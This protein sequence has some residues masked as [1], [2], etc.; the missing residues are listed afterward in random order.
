MYLTNF[1]L[2][3][4]LSL[5]LILWFW[6]GVTDLY[7]LTNSYIY[8]F[9]NLINNNAIGLPFSYFIPWKKKAIPTR[10]L[11]LLVHLFFQY[12]NLSCR[13]E[14][15]PRKFWL[16]F[17]WASYWLQIHELFWKKINCLRE[18][19]ECSNFSLSPVFPVEKTMI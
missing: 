4:G 5:F 11:C 9:L 8:L 13:P 17:L 14:T 10:I 18:I 7:H 2:L 1:K 16:F 19:C 12:F 6:L 15:W 3:L